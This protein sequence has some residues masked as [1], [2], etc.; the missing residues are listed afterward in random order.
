MSSMQV[1]WQVNHKIIN[2]YKAAY[3]AC[4]YILVPKRKTHKL[5]DNIDAIIAHQM[6]IDD[7]ANAI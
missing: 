2:E 3:T 4:M 6:L 7:V 1:N 5:A